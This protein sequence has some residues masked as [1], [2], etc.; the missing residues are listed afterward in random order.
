PMIV[1]NEC[2][3]AIQVINK[4]TVNGQFNENDLDMLENLAN[5]AAIAIK[6]ARLFENEQKINELN[7]LLKISEELTST[8]DLDRVLLSIVNLGSQA[9]QYERAVIALLDKDDQVYIAAESDEVKPDLK[10]KENIALKKIMDYV[11]NLG[12]SLHINNHQKNIPSK[13]I[14]EFI[15]E[16]LDEYDL[17]SMSV[18]ILSDSE[19]NLGLLSMEGVHTILIPPRSESVINTLA[20]QSSI[21]IRNAQL[22][23][24]ITSSGI[25]DRFKSGFKI[26]SGTRRKILITTGIITALLFIALLIPL[27]SNV[28]SNVEIVPE[29]KTQVTS[30]TNGVVKSVLFTEGDFVKKGQIL[31]KLDTSLLQLEKNKLENDLLIVQSKL[32]QLEREGTPSEIYMTQL[33]KQKLQN[34]IEGAN[35]NIKFASIKANR[36]GI[37][38]TQKPEELKDK[39]I[40]QGETVAEIALNNRKSAHIF[41]KEI[42]I[43]NV[44]RGNKVSLALQSIPGSVIKGILTDISQTKIEDEEN[45]LENNSYI[46]YFRS[47]QLN[48]IKSVR[49]GMTGGAKIHTGYKTL[50]QSTLKKVFARLITKVK[51]L[52]TH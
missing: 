52:L 13:D 8:L 36:S 28:H 6:N 49:Y 18:I 3:G 48:R 29:H 44:K 20:N 15:N 23:Q 5:S 21:A 16:Y 39:Q 7:A 4:K 27:P 50:F 41:I 2:V 37:I 51:L 9:V 31:I 24:N 32:Q 19:G 17:Q 11:I 12:S 30:F 33:E 40:T 10:A 14:P 35:Y 22:Y 25:A 47:N 45:E 46:G 43:L 1:A 38:L 34:K 42:D 26:S